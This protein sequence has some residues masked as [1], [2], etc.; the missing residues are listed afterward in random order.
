MPWLAVPVEAASLAEE[1][2][3]TAIPQPF[4]LAGR[5]AIEDPFLS[6]LATRFSAGLF[7]ASAD[8][9]INEPEQVERVFGAYFL[10]WARK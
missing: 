8:G 9:K 6:S 5:R 7:R 3:D 2:E 1:T 10:K 4:L